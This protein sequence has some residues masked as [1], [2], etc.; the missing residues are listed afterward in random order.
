MSKSAQAAADAGVASSAAASDSVDASLASA[1]VSA[2]LG[3]GPYPEAL[4]AILAAYSANANS[5]TRYQNYNFFF[6]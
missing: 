3:Q 1:S 2:L 5:S 4:Q 6:F